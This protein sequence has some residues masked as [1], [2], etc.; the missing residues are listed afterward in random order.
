MF[1]VEMVG[2]GSCVPEH[3]IYNDDMAAFV[4]TS[5]EWITKM[6]GIRERRISVSEDTTELA[7]RAA[8]RALENAG[9]VSEE[10]DLI[11]V[12]TVTPDNF[13][14][15]T[16]CLVQARIGAKGAT[17]FDISAACSGFI[18]GLSIATQFIKNGTYQTA[19]VIGAEVL[20]KITDWSDRN[21]CVLFADGAGAA[22][23]QRGETGIISGITGSDGTGAENLRCPAIPLHNRFMPTRD[24]EPNFATMNGREVFKFAVNMM[25]ECILKVLEGTGYTLDDIKY[26]IPHQANVRIVDAAAKKLNVDREK[27]YMNIQ[28]YGN[29]S[30]ASIPLALDEMSREGLLL[31]G[32]LIIIAGFGGG[33]TYG[34]QLI[35]WTKG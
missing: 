31:P 33:Y 23:L 15:A 27:F 9:V 18:F 34:A 24:I 25:P 12:A 1:D 16:A 6:T 28:K 14:P 32:D 10:V 30:S 11:I 5:D 26:F 8:S 2:T 13:F 35:K 4:D 22:V 17:S 19:L 21:T 3:I 7:F 20:S 29:T